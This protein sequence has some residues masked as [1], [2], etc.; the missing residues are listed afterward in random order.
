MNLAYA[1]PL[2]RVMKLEQSIAVTPP[3]A[4]QRLAREALLTRSFK[5]W[6][7]RLEKKRH[8]A[9]E[10]AAGR[11]VHAWNL[12]RAFVKCGLTP[13]LGGEPMFHAVCV[14]IGS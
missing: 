6:P 3:P 2:E 1:L 9:I 13:L 14:M 7:K 11:P 8:L 5:P 10:I 4:A 12:H